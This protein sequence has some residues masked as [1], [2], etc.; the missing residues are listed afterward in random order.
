MEECL[1]IY[2][3]YTLWNRTFKSAVCDSL[4]DADLYSP[5]NWLSE[6]Y[7]LGVFSKFLWTTGDQATDRHTTATIV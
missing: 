6:V 7:R 2:I 5:L 4:I 1:F 3:F